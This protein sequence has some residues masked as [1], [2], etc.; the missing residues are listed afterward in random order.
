M[1]L[2]NFIKSTILGAVAVTLVACSP[3]T[4]K[5]ETATKE[6]EKI[7]VVASPAPHAEILEV[8][9]PILKEKGY[10][11]QITVVNDYVTPNKIVDSGDADANFFQHTP[12]LNTFNKDN[13]LDLVSVG[14]VHI[15]PMAV[16]SK[17]YKNLNELPENAVVYAST[18][19]SDLGR[20]ISFFVKAGLM[21]LKE[22]T[23]PI[24]ATLED[25]TTN[26][27]N[28][29]I[30][31]EIAPEFLVQTFENNEGDAVIINSN[32]AID[33]KLSPVKDS[34][35]LEDSSS[36]YANLVAAKPEVAKSEKIKALIEVLQ[37]DAVKKFITEKYADGSVVPAK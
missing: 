31:P 6:L 12:Y 21:T 22:G 32:F 25:I 18:S 19:P 28:I 9:K 27:K 11:L 17:K 1:N 10:D 5:P 14:N 33:A 23:D 13:N 29:Q 4:S 35:A 3:S 26:P 8:A 37:G 34:I 16:Y 20:F 30:K 2:K 36:P 7:T 24:T 15:E